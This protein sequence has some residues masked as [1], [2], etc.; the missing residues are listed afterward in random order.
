MGDGE[1]GAYRPVRQPHVPRA[2]ARESGEVRV[3]RYALL[4]SGGTATSA[5]ANAS[6]YLPF[7]FA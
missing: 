4:R 2:L 7:T 3:R 1:P 6:A 5:A